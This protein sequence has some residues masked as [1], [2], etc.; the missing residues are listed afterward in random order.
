MNAIRD[1][2]PRAEIVSDAGVR[3][4]RISLEYNY[5]LYQSIYCTTKLL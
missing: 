2:H 3:I 5:S 1:G 4:Q